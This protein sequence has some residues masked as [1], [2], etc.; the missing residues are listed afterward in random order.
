MRVAEGEPEPQAAVA[1]GSPDHRYHIGEAGTPT[2][3][4]RRLQPV[5]ERKQFAQVEL[6]NI[7]EAFGGWNQAQAEHFDDGGMFDQIYQPN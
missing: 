3:P 5:A 4:R 2:Q 6:F 1:L 7:D